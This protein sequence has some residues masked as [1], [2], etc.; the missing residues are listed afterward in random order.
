MHVADQNNT[1]TGYAAIDSIIFD[2]KPESLRC[3]TMPP[4]AQ[5]KPTQQPPTDKPDSNPKFCNFEEDI[6]GWKENSSGGGFEWKRTNGDL[7]DG[8]TGPQEDYD[9]TGSSTDN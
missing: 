9:D 7:E 6:C 8:I 3:D 5:V 2:Y 1:D 4:Q